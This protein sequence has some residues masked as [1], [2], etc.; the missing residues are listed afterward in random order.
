MY[1]EVTDYL[2]QKNI[3]Y[4]TSGDKTEAIINCLFCEDTKY[5]LYINNTEGCFLCH[6]C[7][8]RGSWKNLVENLGDTSSPQLESNLGS[9][10]EY[11]AQLE[12]STFDPQLVKSYH[13][14]LLDRVK[15]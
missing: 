15:E 13:E 7:G 12:T 3:A 2:S 5:H 14:N 4:E 11:T 9:K 6:K 1:K 8:A 10:I